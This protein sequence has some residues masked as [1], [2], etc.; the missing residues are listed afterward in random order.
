MNHPWH[1]HPVRL[2]RDEANP[3]ECSGCKELG[4]GPRYQCEMDCPFVLHEDCFK[5]RPKDPSR[6]HPLMGN[7]RFQFLW[8]PPGGP[9][10]RLC[11]ACGRD[12]KGFVYH[13]QYRHKLDLH[14]CCMNLKSTMSDPSKSLTLIL[15]DKMPSKCVKCKEKNLKIQSKRPFRGWSYVS[16]CGNYCYHVY[17]VKKLILEKWKSGYL[18]VGSSCSS[19]SLRGRNLSIHETA[20]SRSITSAK[21]SSALARRRSSRSSFTRGLIKLAKIGLSVIISVLLGNPTPLFTALAENLL[22]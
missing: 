2:E 12:V 18:N 22:D 1:D 16:S 5:A 3:F 6:T 11:D 20:S 10:S 9:E 4:S 13:D 15:N 19:S 17:C 7:C 8:E 21:S 14:P